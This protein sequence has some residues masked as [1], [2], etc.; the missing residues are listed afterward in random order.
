GEQQRVQFARTLVQLL[1]GRPNGEY[2]VLFLDEPTASLDPRHQIALLR[3]V[4]ALARDAGVAVLVVLH[5]VN[6]AAAWCDRLLLLS[7]GREV[8]QGAPAGVLTPA[9][10]QAVYG[11]PARVMGHPDMPGQPLV[12]FSRESA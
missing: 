8:A 9:N 4:S 11:L 2:R 1:A 5:D 6:L 12:L 10:L 7:Q 3:A